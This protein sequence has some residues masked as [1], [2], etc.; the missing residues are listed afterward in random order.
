MYFKGLSSEEVKQSLEIHGD[1]KLPSK[2]TNTFFK[3][4]KEN[5]SDPMIKIL[6]LA[7]AINVI[8]AIIGE[9][10]WYEVFGILTAILL[11][12][13]VS[14]FSEF[15][16]ENTFKKL[17]EEASKF[18]SK[19]YRDDSIVEIFSED[20]VKGEYILLQ[21]GDKIPVDGYIIHGNIKVDQSAL[22]GESEEV[23]KFHIENYVKNKE[24]ENDFLCDNFVFRGSVVAAGQCVIIA[25]NIGE[26]SQ[27]GKLVG[28]LS[29][30]ERDSP[31]KVKL[32]KLAKTISKFGYIGGVSIAIAFLIKKIVIDNDLNPALIEQYFNTYHYFIKDLVDAVM[33]GVIIVV[34][35]VPE[36]LPLMIA[37]VSS[38]NMRKM[39]KDNV[40]VRKIVGIET[41]GS[42]NILYTDKT[43]T[44]TTGKLTVIEFIDSNCNEYSKFSDIPKE[45][46]TQYKNNAI[47]NSG[48]VIS[49][50]NNEIKIIGGNSTDRAIIEFLGNDVET[51]G[52]IKVLDSVPFDSKI[53]Y[54]A[55]LTSG[56][57]DL[58][59][60]KGAPEQLLKNCTKAF[61]KNGNIVA[62]D[63]IEEIQNKI[64]EM[65]NRSIRVVAL[66]A[67]NQK[68]L[69]TIF[70][71]DFIFIGIVGIRDEIRKESYLAISEVNTA[72][73]Q[74]VM[75]TGDRKET[76]IAIGKEVGVIKSE[77]DIVLT[78]MEMR[79]LTDDE[80]KEKL[81]R[82]KIVA[83]ALPEDKSRLVRVSQEMNLVTGMTGDGV[84]DSPALKRADV[85]F[86]MGSGTEVA[87]EASDIVIYDDNFSSISKAILYGRTIF[88]SIRKFIIFQLSINVS[89][90]LIS[91]I[92][93]LL[94][95]ENPITIIQMLWINLVMDTLAA[96]AFGGESALKEFMKEKPKKRN[97]NIL[98]SDMKIQI[99]SSSIY[100]TIISL[101]FLLTPTFDFLFKNKG[102]HI[103]DMTIFF[104]LFVF[105]CIINGFN[106]RTT[107]INIFSHIK[108]NKNFIK[109]MLLIAIVQICITCFGGRILR[110]IPISIFD[111]IIIIIISS[112]IIPLDLI[113][114]YL[115]KIKK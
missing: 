65:S 82:I 98:S 79:E 30:D 85:G 56:T 54:S 95:I 75:I 69:S 5:F 49:K 40:L 3:K 112:T 37:I 78:S 29:L 68:S 111:F 110:T 1:N 59:L 31:L 80:L 73:V 41:A 33:L 90:V 86:S 87:K 71:D 46:C 8:F 99:L 23:S 101:L 42:L 114:K 47:L 93:P 14:T 74:V 7:L 15:K 45:I 77:S 81:P 17:Q 67:S 109:V 113:R 63:K 84:N 64:L 28:E 105:I 50:N 53:K 27:Y 70:E 22:N 115:M 26:S 44:L 66:V 107:R 43:G 108:E 25:E 10:H 60:I 20:I 36:G 100:I 97:E 48:A 72:G 96:I 92:A 18:K 104:N 21:T 39:L 83:R 2:D 35:V 102:I 94:N 55:I 61:D 88:N 91:F 51:D 19:V 89:A 9:A 62:F 103:Y 34:V 11:A 57:N 13:F 106:A 38:L 6:L 58:S 16:N 32:T 52:N 12:T 4:Y 76:A 24:N